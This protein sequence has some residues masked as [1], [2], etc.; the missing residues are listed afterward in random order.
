MNKRIISVKCFAMTC[1]AALLFS[2]SSHDKKTQTNQI[3]GTVSTPK[4]PTWAKNAVF[5]Q[6]QRILLCKR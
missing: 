3:T 2:C 5:Y 1:I 4:I 6:K